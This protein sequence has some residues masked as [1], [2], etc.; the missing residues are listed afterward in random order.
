MVN[1]ETAELFTYILHESK[2]FVTH[3]DAALQ[4]I[5][6]AAI[7]S[8][9]I[10]KRRLNRWHYGGYVRCRLHLPTN[11]FDLQIPA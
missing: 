8:R 11:N 1:R 3:M 2:G 9:V 5:I 4:V 6:F 7:L 10:L